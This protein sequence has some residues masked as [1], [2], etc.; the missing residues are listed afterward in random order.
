MPFEA[1]KTEMV[2]RCNTV[3]YMERSKAVFQTFKKRVKL[4]SYKTCFFKLM[5]VNIECKS[6]GFSCNF[7][8]IPKVT[9][10]YY[11]RQEKIVFSTGAVWGGLRA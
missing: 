6:L 3:T 10:P 1:N 5:I 11:S 2:N 7:Y 9:T 4:Q 8:S